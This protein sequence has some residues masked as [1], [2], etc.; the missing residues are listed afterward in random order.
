M[1]VTLGSALNIGGARTDGIYDVETDAAG[2]CCRI[3]L[4]PGTS[5][6]ARR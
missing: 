1:S 5:G 6:S 3:V 4:A 2:E